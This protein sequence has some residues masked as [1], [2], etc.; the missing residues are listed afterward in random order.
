MR[1]QVR[2]ALEA[3]RSTY[4]TCYGGKV[5]YKN[6]IPIF[7]SL[8]N[9]SGFKVGDRVPEGWSVIPTNAWAHK[10]EAEARQ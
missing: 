9:T 7:K 6:G 1:Q 8:P 10:K 2:E 5:Q 4:T 3:R